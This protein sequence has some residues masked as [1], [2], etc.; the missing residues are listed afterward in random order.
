M[1]R[2]R[3]EAAA[4]VPWVSVRKTATGDA[5][6]AGA[7]AGASAGAGA[8]ASAGVAFLPSRP[9]IP[10]DHDTRTERF[11]TRLIRWFKRAGLLDAEAAANML[12]WEHSGHEIDDQRANLVLRLEV[13][14]SSQPLEHLVRYCARPAFALERLS[15]VGGG[16]DKPKR[17]LYTLPRHKRGQWVGSGR[18][19]KAP[20]PDAQ[21]VVNLSPHVGEPVEPPPVS[22]ARG[23]PTEWPEL[24]QAHDDRGTAAVTTLP[25]C[26]WPSSP[27]PLGE[28]PG[29]QERRWPV[30]G[31]R[32]DAVGRSSGVDLQ[33]AGSC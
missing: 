13:R 33:N 17:I 2:F 27:F 5:A 23:P 28:R 3:A 29:R 31:R 12:T 7:T 1:G 15:V 30:T 11:R 6:S 14:V 8:G 9:I 18:N 16:G 21:G 20:A 10:G 32:E 22:P 26:H 19:Q 24:V 4:V 25:K